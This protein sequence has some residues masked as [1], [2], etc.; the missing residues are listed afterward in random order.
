[1]SL[2]PPPVSGLDVHKA[3]YGSEFKFDKEAQIAEMQALTKQIYETYKSEGSKVSE[4]APR[5]L[6]TG[7]PN[8]RRYRKDYSLQLRKN[9]GVVVTYEN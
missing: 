9:G 2:T 5:I 3:L 7:C 4:T 1:M 8:C 6:I